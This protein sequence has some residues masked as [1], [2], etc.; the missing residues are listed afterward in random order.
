MR[1]YQAAIDMS[2]MQKGM[3]YNELTN[4]II[5]FI[6]PFDPI[7][8]G[9]PVYFFE[10]C[11]R[12]KESIKINDGA[13]RVIFN[14]KA[15]EV[16]KDDK[17][18]ELLKFFDTGKATKGVAKEMEMKVKAVKKDSI[19]FEDF[20]SM[21]TSLVDAR[22]DGKKE[23]WLQGREEGIEEG[24]EKGSY[25]AKLETAKRAQAMGL[26]IETIKEITGLSD[27]EIL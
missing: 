19:M 12:E 5:I 20:F 24:I 27:A 7:G 4:T 21:C 11:C 6:T 16:V 2:K 14:T 15:S 26:P 9:L 3:D 10:L 1:A 25:K 13:Y 8:E 23:G 17:L 18:R 22:N